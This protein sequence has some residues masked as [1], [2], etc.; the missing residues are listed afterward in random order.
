MSLLQYSSGSQEVCLKDIYQYIS[1][2]K[3]ILTIPGFTWEPVDSPILGQVIVGNL[4]NK[5]LYFAVIFCTHI[6]NMSD[7][8][9]YVLR[10]I[11][12]E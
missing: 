3:A 6:L 4:K 12:F 1:T 5:G 2:I 7:L 8:F 10:K 11:T 9:L